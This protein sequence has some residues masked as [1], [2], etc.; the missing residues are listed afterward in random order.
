MNVIL[1]A[2]GSGIVVVFIVFI[3][4][5]VFAVWKT[6]RFDDKLNKEISESK[7]HQ[8]ERIEYERQ[9]QEEAERA[10]EEMARRRDEILAHAMKELED[11]T[12]DRAT[13]AKALILADGNEKK[14][15]AEYLKLRL[16]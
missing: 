13:W 8:A 9:K 4:I 2:D 6:K 14:A 7:R 10:K 11:G 5:V 3:G 16:K 1:A 12:Y 15:R